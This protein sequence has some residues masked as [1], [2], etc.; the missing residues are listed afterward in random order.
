MGDLMWSLGK[1]EEVYLSFLWDN[2]EKQ[3][4]EL[5]RQ[6]KKYERVFRAPWSCYAWSQNYPWTF[7][8]YEQNKYLLHAPP[9]I[10]FSLKLA[11]IK[12]LSLTTK[13]I[14]INTTPPLEDYCKELKKQTNMY[15]Q[16]LKHWRLS[17]DS[18]SSPISSI[19]QHMKEGKMENGTGTL[20][21]RAPKVN[22]KRL[23]YP[24]K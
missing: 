20:A 10:F 16:C 17:W 14:L 18:S 3:T 8:L 11:W 4:E 9:P 2:R 5:K 1:R 22:I 23:H 24:D 19:Q 15:D 6:R 12:F 21:C 13:R 7:K